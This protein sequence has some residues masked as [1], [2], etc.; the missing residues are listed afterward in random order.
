MNHNTDGGWKM[1]LPMILCCV[2]M[3]GAL[4][5]LGGWLR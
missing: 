1:W 4:L 2:A 5:L 3:L